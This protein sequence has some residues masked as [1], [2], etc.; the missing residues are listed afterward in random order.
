VNGS[1]ELPDIPTNTLDSPTVPGWSNIAFVFDGNGGYPGSYPDAGSDGT[2]YADFAN[3]RTRIASQEFTVPA[4]SSIAAITWDATTSRG[5][6]QIPYVA[7]LKDGS[8]TIRETNNFTALGGSSE[9]NNWDSETL[10]LTPQ[11]YGPGNYILEFFADQDSGSDLLADNVVIELVAEA[12]SAPVPLAVVQVPAAS[13]VGSI[14]NIRQIFSS[15]VSTATAL[16]TPMPLV[17]IVSQPVEDSDANNAND[18][19]IATTAS[20]DLFTESFSVNNYIT[21]PQ[22]LSAAT[23]FHRA[24]TDKYDLRPLRDDLLSDNTDNAIGDGLQVLIDME[25]SLDLLAESA[26][27]VPL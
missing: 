26:V 19:L 13:I 24:A 22:P 25:D 1:F 18:S 10:L 23:T 21:V 5:A 20:A 27:A 17:P 4:S 8:G 14:E 2:Q 3:K 6:S 16:A 7:R 9:Y 12:P 15:P 11:A